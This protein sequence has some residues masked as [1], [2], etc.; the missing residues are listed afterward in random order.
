MNQFVA[1]CTVDFWI[2]FFTLRSCDGQWIYAYMSLR[3]FMLD[4]KTADLNN[5]VS[6]G[7]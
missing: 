7:V 5:S 4:L 3:K 2:Y 6:L 1:P